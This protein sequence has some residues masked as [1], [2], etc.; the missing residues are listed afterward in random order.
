MVASYNMKNIHLVC[1]CLGLADGIYDQMLEKRISD[2]GYLEIPFKQIFSLTDKING[3]DIKFNCSSQS[4]D[5]VWAIFRDPNFYSQST[6]KVVKG[7]IT[8]TGNQ[9][10]DAFK[11]FADTEHYIGNFYRFKENPN[12]N[13][14]P[15]Y[16]F[17]INNSFIPNFPATAE[18]MYSISMNSIPYTDKEHTHFSLDQ[19]K[20]SYFVLCCRLNLPYSEMRR[21]ISGIDTRGISANMTLHTTGLDTT[22]TASNVVIFVEATSTLRIGSGRE[23][24]VLQ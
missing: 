10:Y 16:Q 4:I 12:S 8:A 13:D 9:L 20:D 22:A 19:Y 24:A 14:K 11:D 17:S 2:V 1:E 5:R 3:N 18:Q 21:L 15:T 23:L 6:P 7:H